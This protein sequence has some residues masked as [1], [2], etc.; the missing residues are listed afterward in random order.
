[1]YK[2]EKFWNRIANY[3]ANAPIKDQQLF[4][5]TVA[6]IQK[7]LLEDDFLLDYGCGTGTYS[8]AIADSVSQI[9]AI[10]FSSS[11]IDIATQRGEEAEK[12]N[13]RFEYLS[14][15]DE[16]LQ[17]GSFD[18]VLAFNVFHLQKDL[19]RVLQRVYQ[20]LKPGGRLISK[21]VC[22]GKY[23]K[24]FV[25][26]FGLISK[27]NIVPSLNVFTPSELESLLERY[28]LK[29]IESKEHSSKDKTRFIVALKAE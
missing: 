9:E 25:F 17:E 29:I 7:H 11:M 1:M 19:G 28:Q 3:Y 14:L 15:F 4:E 12:C 27:F 8:I 22:A 18:V 13:I 23:L 10:D 16:R 5:K 26:L 24:P 6:D 20:L 2:N 21:T